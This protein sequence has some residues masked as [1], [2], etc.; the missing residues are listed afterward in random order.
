MQGLSRTGVR[1]PPSVGEERVCGVLGQDGTF[2]ISWQLGQV[3]A[4]DHG[5]SLS[6]SVAQ[7]GALSHG[8][9]SS[10]T[11][12]QLAKEEVTHARH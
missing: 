11:H 7:Q 6:V 9:W 5:C 2:P 1:L 12:S 10:W 8:G 4:G 3:T